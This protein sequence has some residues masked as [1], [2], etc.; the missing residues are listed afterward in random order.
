[1][2]R[3]PRSDEARRKALATLGHEVKTPVA[4]IRL[5]RYAEML[6]FAFR[7]SILFNLRLGRPVHACLRFQASF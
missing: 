4:G 6:L 5:S 3:P 2:S 1:M 7:Q